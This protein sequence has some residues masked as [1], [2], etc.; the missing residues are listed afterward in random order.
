[1]TADQALR[2]ADTSRRIT[3][4][5]TMWAW[6]RLLGGAA[7]LAV[8]VWRL[9]TGPFLDGLRLVDGWS[10]AAA[11]G[12]A[13][14]TTI[15]SAWRWCL[16][17]RGLGVELPLWPAVGAYYR[18]QFLNTVLPGGVLGD[19]HRGVSHGLDVDDLGRGLRAVAWERTAGQVVQA[20]LA[21]L[22]LLTLPSPVRSSMPVIVVAVLAVGALGAVL[23]TRTGPHDGTSA[24]ARTLRTAGADVRD[25]LL[26]RRTWPGI[27]FAS[28]VV[29]TGHT[30]TFLVAAHTAGSTV[31]L[32]RMLPLA[33]LV[34][35]AMGV[36]TSLGGWG[37]REG[38]AAWAFAAAGLGASQGVATSVVYG[39]MTLVAS[40]PGAA[41]L[42]VGW[43]HRPH[44]RNPGGGEPAELRLP[45]AARSERA[46]SG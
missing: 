1:M 6:A 29:V 13:V 12:I 23:L 18:S 38:A 37:P 16:V 40:L 19:V 32:I 2:T 27:V 35:L 45:T 46:T 7:I 41:V 34:L 20:V 30:A 42:L 25:A 33:L 5:R 44:G 24:W 14:V 31:S 8:L 9:G 11:A 39:V 43:L 21:A 22:V 15:F 26:A 3:T 10:L 28:T 17:S 36:P 4:R